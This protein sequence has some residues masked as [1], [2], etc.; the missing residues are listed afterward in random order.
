MDID[1]V[2]GSAATVIK[3]PIREKKPKIIIQPIMPSLEHVTGQ[4]NY[5]ILLAIYAGL[6]RI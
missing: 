4:C 2:A 6:G 3:P 5:Q 1:A